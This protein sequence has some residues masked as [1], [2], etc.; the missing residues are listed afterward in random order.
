M[1]LLAT[2][3]SPHVT[4]RRKRRTLLVMAAS[5]RIRANRKQDLSVKLGYEPLGSTGSARNGKKG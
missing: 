2:S 1:Y 3:Q 5:P 4:A